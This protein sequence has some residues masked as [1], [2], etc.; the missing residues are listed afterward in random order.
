MCIRDSDLR[1]KIPEG[2][3]Q[4]HFFHEN[5]AEQLP[6]C[7]RG[8]DAHEPFAAANT[9]RQALLPT[10]LFDERKTLKDRD[11]FRGN[12]KFIRS[13]HAFTKKQFHELIESNALYGQELKNLEKGMDGTILEE[14]LMGARDRADTANRLLQEIYESGTASPYELQ[15]VI[16][17]SG[18]IFS[19][20]NDSPERRKVLEYIRLR[21]DVKSEKTLGVEALKKYRDLKTEL[22]PIF[23]GVE[24]EHTLAQQLLRQ[25]E[26]EYEQG[27]PQTIKI[28]NRRGE[29]RNADGDILV[30]YRGRY[31]LKD[32]YDSNEGK[33][34][35]LQ[36]IAGFAKDFYQEPLTEPLYED[37]E[38]SKIQGK[39]IKR[40]KYG[41]ELKPYTKKV[42]QWDDLNERYVESNQVHREGGYN[43]VV[44]VPQREYKN[45][46]ADSI[47]DVEGT[48][49]LIPDARLDMIYTTE[50]GEQITLAHLL[51]R[52]DQEDL[53]LIH[54]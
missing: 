15:T 42:S 10:D 5:M 23:R 6:P 24:N 26:N 22:E 45:A 47:E 2:E 1:A 11:A 53:S 43:E 13:N 8:A 51:P 17:D 52:M 46:L 49:I 7:G 9:Q 21:K 38:L 48:S 27:I 28:I 33:D 44:R 35:D 16:G 29:S 25:A 19:P 40:T 39:R 31:I 20:A 30:P 4:V 41:K 32:M 36:I 14:I 50:T 3:E 54:I 37:E 18:Y 34:E 12:I